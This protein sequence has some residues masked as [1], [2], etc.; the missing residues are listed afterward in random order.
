[1]EADSGVALVPELRMIGFDGEEDKE[2]HP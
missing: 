1:V 2:G